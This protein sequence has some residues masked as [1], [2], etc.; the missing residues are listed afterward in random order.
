MGDLRELG[1][2]LLPF[3]WRHLLE[4]SP[5]D[6]VATCCRDISALA[7]TCRCVMPLQCQRLRAAASPLHNLP[8][9]S[10]AAQVVEACGLHAAVAVTGRQVLAGGH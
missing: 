5:L 8:A 2:D 1:G 9:G 10:P 6:N 7:V 3:V 4:L